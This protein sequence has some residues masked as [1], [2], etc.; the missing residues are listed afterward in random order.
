MAGLDLPGRRIQKVHVMPVSL[1]DLRRVS[2]IAL[3]TETRD[4]RLQQDKG[5]GWPMRAGHLVGL[6]IAWRNDSGLCSTYLPI[7]HPASDNLDRAQ[8]FAWV[9]DLLA[10]G[11]PRIVTQNG[12]YDFGWLRTE[13]G[14]AAPADGR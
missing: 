8:V 10:P 12:L 14:I 7:A 5:P 3:D 2:C 11:G 1:P 4:D 13:A 6:S 9:R